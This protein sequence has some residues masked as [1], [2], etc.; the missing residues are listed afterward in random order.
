M[1]I[2]RT[3]IMLADEATLNL[4]LLSGISGVFWYRKSF[5]KK[6]DYFID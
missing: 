2:E 3:N 5:L 4:Y 6:H 1:N